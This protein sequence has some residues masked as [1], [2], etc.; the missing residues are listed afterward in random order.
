[1]VDHQVDDQ[2]HAPL[3]DALKH[4][5]KVLHG[6]EFRVDPPVIGNIVPVV[7]VGRGIEGGDPDHVHAQV[8]QIVQ[9]FRDA[10]QIADAVPVR[11]LKGAG[12]NLIHDRFLPPSAFFVHLRY[13]RF[14]Q[15]GAVAKIATAH[16]TQKT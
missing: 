15:K 3:V 8:F 13:L 12:I 14:F 11:I 7:I 2:L 5:V 9:P 1:M 10:V 16:S 6:A 4:A